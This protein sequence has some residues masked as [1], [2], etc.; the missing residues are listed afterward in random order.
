MQM[1]QQEWYE[2]R[3]AGSPGTT[4]AIEA[5]MTTEGKAVGDFGRL[6]PLGSAQA[7]RFATAKEAQDYLLTSTIAQIY[8]LEVVRCTE[9]LAEPVRS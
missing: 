1:T 6:V 2:V 9:T 3:V 8:P 5:G 4:L 7:R